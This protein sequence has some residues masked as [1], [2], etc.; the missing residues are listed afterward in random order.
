M[1]QCN[2]WSVASPSAARVTIETQIAAAFPTTSIAW[3]NIPFTAPDGQ[4]LKV[5][6]L[7]GNGTITTKGASGLN[8]VT[9][10]L[11]LAVFEPKDLGDGSLDT[12]AETARALFNRVR[13]T[14]IWFGAAS[15]PVRL[16][17]ESWR[18]L[19]VS[20]PFRVIEP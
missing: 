19:V 20:I 14:D 7:W 11:Q 17:E 13:I 1:R 2:W 12:L 16:Y 9:G 18:S 6:F 4:W 10:V 8:F 15:G 5:D 3:P